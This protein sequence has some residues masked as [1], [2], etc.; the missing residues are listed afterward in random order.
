MAQSKQ[1]VINIPRGVLESTVPHDAELPPVPEPIEEGQGGD[2]SPPIE[3]PATETKRGARGCLKR[4]LTGGKDERGR[5]LY[6]SDNVHLRLRMVAIDRGQNISK[7]AEEILD[8]ILP[9][10]FNLNGPSS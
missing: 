7:T 10:S 8:K 5:R 6:L 1:S 4:T 3:S 9:R 2:V